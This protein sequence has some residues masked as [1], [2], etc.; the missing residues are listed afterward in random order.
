MQN[1][2]NISLKR[3]EDIGKQYL[4]ILHTR[5]SEKFLSLYEEMIDA[6]NFSFYIIL[7][8]CI[9]PTLFYYSKMDHT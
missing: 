1:V 9:W 4:L 6:Q 7:L 5:L 2:Q 8:N 3:V